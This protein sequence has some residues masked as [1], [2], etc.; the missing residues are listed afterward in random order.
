[1]AKPA[2]TGHTAVMAKRAP[3]QVPADDPVR[4]LHRQLDYYPTPPWAARAGGEIINRIDP[5]PGWTCWE[6]ACG[7]G[8]MAE[9]LREYFRLLVAT[10][11]YSYSASTIIYDFLGS[12]PDIWDCDWIVSNP[13]FEKGG[14]F[15]EL[16]L[17]RAKRGVAMLCRLAFIEGMQRYRLM[18][19]LTL[20]APF[21]ERVPMQLGSW[22]PQ[23]SSAS[24]YAWFIWDKHDLGARRVELIPPGT[25][26]RLWRDTDV[27]RFGQARDATPIEKACEGED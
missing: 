25:K 17:Q 27:A 5:G 22:N 19:Q 6:P 8:H 2:V 13:P 21:S 10:D 3:K 18:K 7:E 11:V 9:P 16:A 4:R 23:L 20:L 26:A 14:Q 24:A 1:M 15:V 12:D